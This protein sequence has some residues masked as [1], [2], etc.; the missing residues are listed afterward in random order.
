MSF[1]DAAEEVAESDIFESLVSDKISES[2]PKAAKP[3]APRT[4]TAAVTVSHHIRH[5]SL[6]G[7]LAGAAAGA[8]A[9]AA[10]AWVVSTVVTAAAAGLAFV[11]VLALPAEGAL[12]VACTYA[13]LAKSA[14]VTVG[15]AIASSVIAD[16]ILDLIGI[17]D[18]IETWVTEFVDGCF[19]ADD[20]PVITG[21]SDV[22]IEFKAAARAMIDQVACVD[23]GPPWPTIATGSD[24]VWVNGLPLA[25]I[26]D[27]TVCGAPLKQGAQSV[28]VGG[29]T[30][31]SLDIQ[32][33]FSWWKR[34]LIDNFE[35]LVALTMSLKSLI[36]AAKLAM[37]GFVALGQAAKNMTMAGLEKGAELATKVQ[38]FAAKHL[39]ELDKGLRATWNSKKPLK[40]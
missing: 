28:L 4:P 7:A 11:A 9:G 33:E 17:K 18:D 1:R 30:V 23:H 21:S 16:Q 8:V 10:V 20:G 19:P 5:S 24:S 6:F 32:D 35:H 22:F 38:K 31:S 26:D 36:K 13:V 34:F 29:E 15:V 12:V 3:V 40:L 37:K 14:V 25:R 39:D 27:R 2:L